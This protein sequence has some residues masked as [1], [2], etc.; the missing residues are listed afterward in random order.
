[1]A[2]KKHLEILK[3]GVEV[4][5]KWRK[6]NPQEQPDLSGAHLFNRNLSGIDLHYASLFTA[7]LRNSDLSFANLEGSSLINARLT[8]ANLLGANLRYANFNIANLNNVNLINADLG[9]GQFSGS[10]FSNA[11]L[12]NANLQGALFLNTKLYNANLSNC[13]IY[14]I[15]AWDVQLDETIQRDLV[16]TRGNE[17]SITVDNLEVAQFIYLLLQNEKIRHIIDTITTKIVLILGRFTKT[18]KPVLDA[19][20]EELRKYDYVPIMFDFEKPRSRDTVETITTLA[21]MANFIIAD[22]TLPKSIPMELQS[23]VESLPSVPVMP[24]LKGKSKAWDM[25]DHIKK[26]PWVLSIYRYRDLD[27]LICNLKKK[28]IDP[29]KAKV[30][31]VRAKS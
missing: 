30:I 4:W 22:M 10:D 16:I 2:N 15:A 6:S 27:D 24:L 1:M 31:E 28:V 25:F 5:N 21:R 8:G 18:R 7:D 29:T 20:R 3:K 26:Y 12:S 9:M 19:I 23:I 11:D 14:G 13:K 17:P